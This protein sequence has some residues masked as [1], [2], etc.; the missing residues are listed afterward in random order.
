MNQAYSTAPG[1]CMGL[2]LH[3]N[4]TLKYDTQRSKSHSST[5]HT[6]Y[7]GISYLSSCETE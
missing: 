7:T 3:K 5:S 4:Y 1:T 6:A 2:W